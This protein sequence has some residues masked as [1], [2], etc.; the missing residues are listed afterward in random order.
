[1]HFLLSDKLGIEKRGKRM[2]R[3]KDSRA[4]DIETFSFLV[5]FADADFL[6]DFELKIMK[7]LALEDGIIDP[8]EK[9][10][11]RGIF[12]RI[13]KDNASPETR[14]EIKSFRAKFNI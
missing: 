9:A 6:D 4:R 12:E 7:N 1:M 10:V 13:T 11:L 2:T 14:A 8:K 3:E 5:A